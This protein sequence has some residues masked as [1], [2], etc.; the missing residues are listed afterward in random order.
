MDDQPR[1]PV[2]APVPDPVPPARPRSRWRMY[3]SIAVIAVAFLAGLIYRRYRSTRR[4]TSPTSAVQ[5][6]IPKDVVFADENQLK[7]LTIQPVAA[8]DFTVDREVTGKVGFNENRLTPVFPAYSG[9]VVEALATKGE[10]VRKGQP[11][12]VVESPDYV[13]AQTDLATARGDVAKAAAILKT[14]G[15]NVERSRRLFVE[16]AV[17]KKD[18]QSAEAALT[19]A[20]AELRRSLTALAVAQSRLVIFGKTPADINRLKAGVDRNLTIAAPIAGTVVD[21]Q[22]GPG[23]ILK[24]DMTTPLFQ[25]SDLSELWVHGD[26]FES[27]LPN[28]RL[29]APAEIRVE[30]YPKRVFPARVSF[31]NPTVDPATR[32]VHVRCEVSNPGGRLKP[33]MFA[34]LKITAAAKQSVPVIP[35]TA[36]VGRDGNSFVLVE[37]APGRFRKRR[38]EIG[39]EVDGSVMITSGL[40]VGERIVTK[41]A[42]LLI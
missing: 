38:V 36:V 34:K 1:E 37:E 35:A 33:D 21:R 19:L 16:D 28:I 9:R 10:R 12:L 32:T 27:D 3:V 11:L 5:A 13:A 8:R 14:A 26:V 18:L 4:V 40:K 31:I 30:S 2:E 41:G 29:G 15:V 17:S 24:S 42:V 25:I 39:H 20:Q 7:N 22:V 6:N 23:Q